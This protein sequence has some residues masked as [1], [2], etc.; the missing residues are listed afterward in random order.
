M[1]M[2]F[3]K[4]RVNSE[5]LAGMSRIYSERL[6]YEYAPCDIPTHGFPYEEKLEFMPAPQGLRLSGSGVHYAIRFTLPVRPT[7][8]DTIYRLSFRTEREGRWNAKN[9]Q[10]LLYID[11]KAAQGIDTNHTRCPIDTSQK[12]ECYLHLYSGLEGGDFPLE[13]TLERI[14]RELDALWYDINVPFRALKCLPADSRDYVR[15]RDIL[16]RA[17]ILLDYRGVKSDDFKRSAVLCR[18]FLRRELYEKKQ[19]EDA[20]VVN[21]IGHTHIDVAWQWQ[22]AQ[23][24]EK[25]QRSFATVLSLMKRYPDY[26]F[27]SS[28]PQLYAY[29]KE[30]DP[31]L[32][33]RIKEAVANGSWIPEGAMWLEA[34]TNLTSGESLVRQIVYGKRFFKAEFGV[35]SHVL[36]LPDVFGYSGALPQIMKKSG[37]DSFFTA[38]ISWSETN[39]M[40]HDVFLWQGIDGSEIFSSLISTYVNVDPV[41]DAY[42]SARDF[43]DKSFTGRTLITLG[44]GDGGGGTTADMLEAYSRLKGG[45]PGM[46]RLEMTGVSEYF[47]NVRRDFCDS[48]SKLKQTPRWVGE[49][50]LEMHR[51]TYTTMAKNKKNNRK[52]ELAMLTSETAALTDRL[53]LGGKYPRGALR[54]AEQTILLDQFHD[55]LPGSSIRAVYDD[56]DADYA[57]VFET[58]DAVCGRALDNIVGSIATDGGIFVYNPSPFEQS[59]T[60][61]VFGVKYNAENIP[62]HGWRVVREKYGSDSVRV[63][64]HVIENEFIRAEFDENY[65]LKSIFDFELGEF[66]PDRAR[67]N[68]LAVF[69]D[70]PR[71]YDAWEITSYYTQKRFGIDTYDSVSAIDGGFSV[72]RSYG[73]SAIVQEIV[74]LPHSRRIDFKTRIDWQE[75]HVLLKAEFPLDIRAG[76][77]DCEIAFGNI[78]RPT[79]ANTSWDAAKF[80]VPAHKWVDMSEGG[81]G[82]SLMND[83]KYGYSAQGELL[84]LTLLKAPGWPNPEADRGAHEFTYSLLLHKDDYRTDTVKEAYALNMPLI[85]RPLG[86]QSGELPES[87]SLI[88]SEAA[89]AVIETVKLAEE[90]ESVIVRMYEAH[91]KKTAANIICG[92]DFE[93]V[94]ECD[95]LE[96]TLCELPH[97]GRRLTVRLKNFE[98]KTL[99]FVI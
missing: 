27:M 56:T 72:S 80:E 64:D 4:I 45:L 12:H 1:D 75:D 15:L 55:I 63:G 65:E 42:A 13:L 24:R 10:G 70:Y 32:Y 25:A 96:N 59:G 86:A 47:E 76:F 60:V 18:E 16:D 41:S 17:L 21:V 49:L 52:S 5:K 31:E 89:N 34:D 30:A 94:Y 69:E 2:S 38:K 7:D 33:R 48:A 85:A 23:S 8:A 6:E 36:W 92:F 26:R 46:P 29:V 57:R 68:R 77:V 37:I 53:L 3:E 9:P 84:S 20:P 95:L 14:D 87:F 97:E 83:C 67:A 44:Y 71:A 61:E 66:I 98:I 81:R 51:G 79:H 62:A 88:S 73:H 19:S 43:K 50:Y 74:L 99:K 82:A 35:D 40:P 22:T 93:R 78:K 11:G 54:E 28:Q 91:D 90:G 39:R 58:L